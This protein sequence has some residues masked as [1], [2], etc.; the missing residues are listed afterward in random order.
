MSVHFDEVVALQYAI[1]QG[2]LADARDQARWFKSHRMDVPAP[3]WIPYINEMRVAAMLIE[4]APDVAAAGAQL[5]RLGHACSSCHQEQNANVAF[6]SV[7]APSAEDTAE[8]QMARHQ[9]AAARLW[10]GLVG[11]S[12]ERWQQGAQMMAVSRLDV[13]GF[14][15]AKPSADVAELAERLRVQATEALAITRPSFRAAFFGQMM[16]TCASCH[17]IVRP[18]AIV[19]DHQY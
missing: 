13:A 16:E 17:S 14:S 5:G 2:R 12:D 19:R 4:T 1:A 3:S 8:A 9:W 15:H 18:G 7:P 11:P 6:A 10:E